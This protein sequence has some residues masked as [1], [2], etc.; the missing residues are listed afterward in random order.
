MNRPMNPLRALLERTEARRR[1]AELADTLDVTF[2]NLA[3]TT[4]RDV[5]G[6]LL[7]FAANFTS[8]LAEVHTAAWGPEYDDQ[9]Q[10]MEFALMGQAALLRMVAATERAVTGTAP[11]PDP[12]EFGSEASEAEAAAWT[13]LARTAEPGKRAVCLHRLRTLVAQDWGGQ[14]AEVLVHLAR[15]EAGRAIDEDPPAL[16][17]YW[18]VRVVIA[19]IFVAL[20]VPVAVPGLSEAARAGL[21]GV[22]GSVVA[23]AIAV[24][25]LTGGSRG[26]S[27]Q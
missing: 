27:S 12:A 10:S 3:K 11:W 18:Q 2:S 9:G 17:P 14:A 20:A 16:R 4:D 23:A 25:W 13:D 24:M 22:L 26:S 1:Y 15:I 21:L 8:Q 5:C 6:A 7:D 19:A